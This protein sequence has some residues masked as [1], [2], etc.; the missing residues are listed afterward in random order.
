MEKNAEE[1]DMKVVIVGDGEEAGQV[2]ERL[3]R[4]GLEV[5]GGA[6]LRAVGVPAD[7][8]ARISRLFL[9][10][11]IPL[12]NK[13][14]FYLREAVKRVLEDASYIHNITKRLY[15]AVGEKFGAKA[16]DV[17]RAVRHAVSVAWTRKEAAFAS[18][19]GSGACGR[20][21]TNGEFIAMVADKLLY[22]GQ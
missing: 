6:P 19:F 11:G 9:E 17:E 21:P 15:P 16:V 18:V 13:G 5:C 1:E 20:R 7:A 12:K 3:R 10:V 4:E 2:A 14:S 22:G 8:D